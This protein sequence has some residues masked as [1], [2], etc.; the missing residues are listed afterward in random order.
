MRYC[1]IGSIIAK[2]ADMN[3][4]SVVKTYCGHGICE[5]FHCAPNVPH[6]AKNKAKGTMQVCCLLH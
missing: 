3:G 5:H 4:F 1:D 2:H 6:Y